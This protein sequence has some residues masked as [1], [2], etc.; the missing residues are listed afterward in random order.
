M[1]STR[2]YHDALSE[3]ESREELLRCSGT[4]FDP[5]V[6]ASFLEVLDENTERRDRIDHLRTSLKD[7]NN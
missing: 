2:S 4:Q 1:T 6:V 3:E 7:D 5:K